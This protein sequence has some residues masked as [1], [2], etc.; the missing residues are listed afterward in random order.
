MTARESEI[1]VAAW[2][3]S[4]F[5][6][7][8]S[9][10]TL[11]V[12]P[13]YQRR[14]VWAPKDQMLLIDSIARGVPIGAITLYADSS[15][16]YDVWEVID[17]KQRLTSVLDFLDD[18]LTIKTSYIEKAGLDDDEFDVAN[19]EVTRKYHDRPYS[20]LEIQYK[21]R[22]AQYQIP[23]FLVRGDRSAAIRSFARMNRSTYSLKPQEIRNAFFTGTS[24]L[25]T[26][27]DCIN[28]LD[29]A[30]FGES[31]TSESS[32]LVRMGGISA[33]SWDRMQDLQLISELLVLVLH[34][35]QHRRDSLDAFY[36]LYR[37]P[38]GDAAKKLAQGS[39]DLQ[40]ILQQ[41]WQLAQETSLQAYHFPSSCE[42][43]LYGLV[44]ALR[45]RGLLTKPQM[46]ALGKELIDVVSA[47]RSETE[48]YVNKVRKGE[49]PSPG[50]FEPL[51]EQY[52]RGFLGGQTNSKARRQERIDVWVEVIN[53]MVSTLD[54]ASAFTETQRRLIWANSA[55]KICA[56]CGEV[57]EWREFHAG[58]RLAWSLGGRTVVENGRVE[59]A[60]CNMSA[61]PTEA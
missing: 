48:K 35:V 45:V 61:G 29:V 5:E 28:D 53:G 50:E 60:A 37:D 24:F 54:T 34:D 23:I 10:G 15:R 4:Q 56:R 57:V 41:I 39:K 46:N 52:G 25:Q 19:D 36:G 20:D 40:A 30:A 12:S 59:H 27:I 1:R 26:V 44:G 7:A 49:T 22:L 9:T 32:L 55:D 3:V 11:I 18:K 51:V 21:M 16:G 43:D 14:P 42:H 58:H 33:G 8:R 6:Q 47:F 13:E 17:G 38:K 31:G 2:Q